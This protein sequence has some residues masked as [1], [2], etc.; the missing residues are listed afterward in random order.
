[1]IAAGGNG[2]LEFHSRANLV[3]RR[4]G[5]IGDNP[6]SKRMCLGVGLIGCMHLKT[7]HCSNDDAPPQHQSVFRG[8]CPINPL[9]KHIHLLGGSSSINTTRWSGTQGILRGSRG[10]FPPAAAMVMMVVL[11]LGGHVTHIFYSYVD[12]TYTKL[13]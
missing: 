2:P 10:P 4:V 8:I 3:L 13:F 12:F 7:L 5:L 9:K 6:P 1:M 11:P